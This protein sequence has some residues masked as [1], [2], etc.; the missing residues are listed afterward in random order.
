MEDHLGGVHAVQVAATS[1]L[2]R[3]GGHEVVLETD[4]RPDQCES[5]RQA[6][7][8]V[9]TEIARSGAPRDQVEV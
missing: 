9:I 8:L 1:S 5:L 3:A 2:H 7:L 6:A 4:C